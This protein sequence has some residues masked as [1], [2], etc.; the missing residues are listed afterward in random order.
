MGVRGCFRRGCD[1]IMT[2]TYIS[3]IGYICYDCQKE[4]KQYLERNSIEN[5]SEQ[6]LLEIL[7]KFMNLS[8]SSSE[9]IDIDEFFNKNTR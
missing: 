1:N 5:T 2:D 6:Q 9:I 7:E 3:G 8:K 4:F